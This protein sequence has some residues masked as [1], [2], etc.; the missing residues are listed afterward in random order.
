MDLFLV[1]TYFSSGAPVKWSFQPLRSLTI[2]CDRKKDLADAIKVVALD[3]HHNITTPEDDFFPF[4]TTEHTKYVKNI[5]LIKL[6][7]ICSKYI[8][9]FLKYVLPCSKYILACLKYILTCSKYILTCSKYILTFS[10]YIL[11]SSDISLFTSYSS[12]NSVKYTGSM[13]KK[14]DEF[15]FTPASVLGGSSGEVTIYVQDEK[16]QLARDSISI[17]LESGERYIFTKL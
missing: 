13:I 6:F 2:N 1:W 14:N 15:I 12:G 3:K 17:L 16:K 9:T 8:L 7:V 10:K 5:F 4:V 11:T